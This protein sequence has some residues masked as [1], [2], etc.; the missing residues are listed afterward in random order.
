M[1]I[2]TMIAMQKWAEQIDTGKANDARVLKA[3]MG[4]MNVGA[5]S[6]GR[7]MQAG[8]TVFFPV[9]SGYQ[10]A[11]TLTAADDYTVRMIFVR[12]GKVSVKAEIEGV[13][14]EQVGEVA[15]KASCF[16]NVA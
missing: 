11:V 10:V 4:M 16:E 3:Q 5:I 7:V 15:Y 13:Y 14:A 8:A 6:G 2:K 1:N 12:A 9:A